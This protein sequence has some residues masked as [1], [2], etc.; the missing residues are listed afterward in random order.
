[1]TAPITAGAPARQIRGPIGHLAAILQGCL[2][3]LVL[4]SISDYRGGYTHT[5]HKLA[6]SSCFKFLPNR[7]AASS[8]Y[9]QHQHSTCDMS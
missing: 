9:R 6:S 4:A 3:R 5:C 2:L 1:M 7:L 8:H